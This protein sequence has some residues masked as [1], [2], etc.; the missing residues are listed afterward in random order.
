MNKFLL[1]LIKYY[2]N[3]NPNKSNKGRH[4]EMN[5]EH[6]IEI[7]YKV[8]ITGSQWKHINSPLHYTTY[9]K[10]LLNGIK[11]IFFKMFFILLLNF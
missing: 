4:N 3:K 7:I 8:L 6:Y 11:V 5:I 10:N 1:E 2:L 9:H